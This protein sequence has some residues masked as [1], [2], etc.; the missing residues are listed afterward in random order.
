M[1]YSSIK[2]NNKSS[3]KNTLPTKEECSKMTAWHLPLSNKKYKKKCTIKKC[4]WENSYFGSYCKDPKTVTRQNIKKE[5][6]NENI[7]L[8]IMSRNSLSSKLKKCNLADEQYLNKLIKKYKEKRK[9]AIKDLV[10]LD[11]NVELILCSNKEI[12]TIHKNAKKEGFKKI[13]SIDK[14]LR[15]KLEEQDIC[16]NYKLG[17]NK[18]RYRNTFWYQIERTL[19]E[20]GIDPNNS[21]YHLAR[22]IWETENI[23][24]IHKYHKP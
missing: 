18:Y 14:L 20:C 2:K 11:N 19:K 7:V 16:F 13:S 22:N 6:L 3:K 15:I 5:K 24:S 1:S 12:H 23:K 21:K 8:A 9:E 17:Y 10:N 4:I